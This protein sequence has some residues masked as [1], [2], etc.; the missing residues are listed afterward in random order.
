MKMR[1]PA[2]VIVMVFALALIA[3]ACSSKSNTGGG[4]SPSAGGGSP[5]GGGG[6]QTVSIKN[7]AFD[8][9]TLTVSAGTSQIVVTNND[10]VTHTFTLDEGS[11]STPIPAGQTVTVTVDISATIGW[12]CSIHPKMTG[13]LT[14]A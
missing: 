5:S 11:V 13:T 12:H 8:P 3:A 7:F 6:G 2:G 10:S 9:N 4:T 1:R 14:V